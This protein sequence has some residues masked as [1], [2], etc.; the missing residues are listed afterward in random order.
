MA[1][2]VTVCVQ[3]S[4]RFRSK[5]QNKQGKIVAVLNNFENKKSLM[6]MTRKKKLKANYVNP[7]WK[8]GGIFII[9]YL[10]HTNS[11]LFYKTR[12]YARE[13]NYKFIWCRD[14]K[15]FI[16]KDEKTR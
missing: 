6:D 5:V 16:R 1:L 4:F 11:N 12:L 15:I 13:H 7:K 10:T 3:N 8:D 2:G 14:C 9:N